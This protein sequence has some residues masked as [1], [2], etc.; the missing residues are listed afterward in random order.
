[1]ISS[2]WLP[3]WSVVGENQRG[4]WAFTSPVMRQLSIEVRWFRQVDMVCWLFA[5]FGLVVSRGGM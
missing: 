3:L 4:E 2:I 1:M 5:W